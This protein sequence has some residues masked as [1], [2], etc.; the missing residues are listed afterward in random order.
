MRLHKHVS[1]VKRRPIVLYLVC[2]TT[3]FSILFFYIQSAF[4]VDSLSSYRNFETIRVLSNFQS[5]VQQCVD[6]EGLGLTTH[7]IDHCKF[8]LKY[9]EATFSD[10]I[11]I[12]ELPFKL[13][14]PNWSDPASI[15]SKATLPDNK[16]LKRAPKLAQPTKGS[17]YN[18]DL[19]SS[20]I[21][22]DTAQLA[23][24]GPRGA[25]KSQL[26]ADEVCQR[27]PSHC[28]P[29]SLSRWIPQNTR[30][31]L[32]EARMGRRGTHCLQQMG[33]SP[34]A[35]KERAMSATTREIHHDSMENVPRL[36]MRSN[37]NQHKKCL[38]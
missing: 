3:L 15:D 12:P 4:F 22:Q 7:I 19:E 6:N 21:D 10:F 28:T 38:N 16:K 30:E 1:S 5:N 2:A 26:S 9:L 36:S 24:R 27:M 32:D 34:I 13:L 35:A 14:T 25:Q 23:Q 31:A 37:E 17:P 29:R 20:P 8:I 11:S 18:E 33:S